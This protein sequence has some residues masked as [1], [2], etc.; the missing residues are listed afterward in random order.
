VVLLWQALTGSLL[1]ERGLVHPNRVHV[2]HALAANILASSL[3]EHM[4]RISQPGTSPVVVCIGTDRSTGDSL[5]PLIGSALQEHLGNMPVSVYGT[6]DE[7]VH[8]ANLAEVIEMIE[9]QTPRRMVLA[10]DACLG[11]SEN[12]GYISVKQ[13]AL[14]PGTGVNKKLPSVGD[15][16]VVGVVNV[17]GFMEYF[18][19]QNT[20]LSLVMRMASVI[21]DA[22][23]QCMCQQWLAPVAATTL[24][25][26]LAQP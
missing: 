9:K 15:L 20:R 1:P 10:I 6:L 24:P 13:G 5:G 19:L 14:R 16:H 26:T 23:E 8:A 17:G 11:K 22:I 18:V 4:T 21:S 3:Y 2:E 25:A 12:V 7:P